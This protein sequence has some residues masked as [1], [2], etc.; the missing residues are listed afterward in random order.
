MDYYY[1]FL[2]KKRKVVPLFQKRQHQ[3]SLTA[4]Q[5]GDYYITIYFATKIL[6]LKNG[7]MERK[8]P[9]LFH[10]GFLKT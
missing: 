10:E 6:T 5:E 9:G 3:Y 7:R 8:P 1:C 2:K 4:E